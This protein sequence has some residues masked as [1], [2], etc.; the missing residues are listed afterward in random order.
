MALVA[1]RPGAMGLAPRPVSG[2]RGR[3]PRPWPWKARTDAEITELAM[4]P[5]AGPCSRS[6]WRSV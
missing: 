6:R 5:R 2:A 4:P 1:P 3:D